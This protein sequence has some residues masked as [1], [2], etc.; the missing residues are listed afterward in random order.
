MCK[1]FD[2]SNVSENKN[3]D[4]LGAII[5]QLCCRKDAEAF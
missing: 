1:E 4:T 2:I 3:V 5:G